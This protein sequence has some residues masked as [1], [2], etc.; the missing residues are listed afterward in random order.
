MVRAL[1]WLALMTSFGCA[2]IITGTS[3]ELTVT[4]T[5]AGAKAYLDG[6]VL[7]TTPFTTHVDRESKA[8]LEIQKDGYRTVRL[9]LQAGLNPWFWGNIVLGGLIGSTTDGI[10]G[11]VHEYRQDNYIVTLEP[12]G[13]N[14]LDAKTALTD[15]QKTKEYIVLG[16]RAILS[17]LRA[18]EGEHLD[19]LLHLLRVSVEE[20]PDAVRKIGALAEVYETIP[21][22]ADRVIEL[23]LRDD[24]S[25]STPEDSI[26]DRGH[27]LR[28]RRPP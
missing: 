28:L 13:T 21:E 9:P 5:P 27:V 1:A 18:G 20:R 23:Y 7:G 17:D 16:Y 2:S 12:L 25:G 8:V 24:G 15:R 11:A 4:S 14:R 3:Q 19:S 6:R 22:F 10:S 26:T